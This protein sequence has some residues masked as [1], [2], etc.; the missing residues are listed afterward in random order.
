MRRYG[1]RGRSFSAIDLTREQFDQYFNL[2]TNMVGYI[3]E[4]AP[5][6]RVAAFPI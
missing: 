4:A 1:S 2:K 3:Q 6:F 5:H